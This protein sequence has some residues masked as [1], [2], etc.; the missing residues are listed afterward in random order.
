MYITSTAINK[1]YLKTKLLH[2]NKIVKL[3]NGKEEKILRYGELKFSIEGA[4][5]KIFKF[6]MLVLENNESIEIILWTDF[7]KETSQKL[8]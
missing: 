4:E 1:I 6:D 7:L 5:S 8:I 2:H 3:A